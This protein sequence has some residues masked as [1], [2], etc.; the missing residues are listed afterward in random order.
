MADLERLAKAQSDTEAAIEMQQ[1]KRQLPHSHRAN[2]RSPFSQKQKRKDHLAT[3]VTFISALCRSYR[4]RW[5]LQAVAVDR[6][7]LQDRLDVSVVPAI[8]DTQPADR[9]ERKVKERILLSIA[10]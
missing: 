2:R 3:A 9:E 7:V 6:G 1:A 10:A 8:R 4:A 5:P